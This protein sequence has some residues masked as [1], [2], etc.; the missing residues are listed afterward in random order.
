MCAFKIVTRRDVCRGRRSVHIQNNDRLIKRCQ[1]CE[2]INK[3]T[4]TKQ[5]STKGKNEF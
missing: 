3:K 1:I 5:K 2:L 4:N